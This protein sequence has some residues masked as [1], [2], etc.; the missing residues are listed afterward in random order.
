MRVFATGVR[1]FSGWSKR[2]GQRCLSRRGIYSCVCLFAG[3]T[4]TMYLCLSHWNRRLSP[5]SDEGFGPRPRCQSARTDNVSK[6]L[7][8]LQAPHGLGQ[9]YSSLCFSFRQATFLHLCPHFHQQPCWISHT[10]HTPLSA[11][12]PSEISLHIAL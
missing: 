1:T 8:W 6:N 2:N 9:C 4:V 10:P 12:L 3:A 7:C 11:Y 5:H